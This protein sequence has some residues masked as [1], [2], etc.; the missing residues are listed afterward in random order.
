MW[1]LADVPRSED[2]AFDYV[3]NICNVRNTGKGANSNM[4][5]NWDVRNKNKERRDYFDCEKMMLVLPLAFAAQFDQM[6]MSG[7]AVK[8]VS[9]SELQKKKREERGRR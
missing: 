8:P 1:P 6:V 4:R 2:K 9:L 7:G 3:T 5:Q